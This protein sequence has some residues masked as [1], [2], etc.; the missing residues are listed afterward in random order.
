[1]SGPPEHLPATVEGMAT[2]EDAYGDGLDGMAQPVVPEAEAPSAKRELEGKDLD[3][4]KAKQQKTW[5]D[6]PSK[7]V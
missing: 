3:E 1:M 6:S 7:A 5:M 4:Q 2:E